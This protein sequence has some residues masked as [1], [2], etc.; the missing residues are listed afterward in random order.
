MHDAV[1][2]AKYI[3]NLCTLNGTPISDLQLQ[4]ILYYVQINFFRILGVP[5]FDNTIEAWPYGPVVPDVYK[6]FGK[7]GS[8]KI[9]KLYHNVDFPDN[10]EH[11]INRVVEACISIGPW[12]LVEL[13]H[14]VG[15]PWQKTYRG[16]KEKIPMNVIR[17]YAIEGV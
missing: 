16:K 3:V 1:D 14:K 11:L 9:C 7:Y 17:E 8:S 5:A 13:S 12:E 15:G 2:I 10:E 4:K 6:E